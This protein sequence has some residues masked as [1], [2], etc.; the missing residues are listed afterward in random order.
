MK[1]CRTSWGQKAF[2]M[3]NNE[4]KFDR[5]M[6]FCPHKGMDLAKICISNMVYCNSLIASVNCCN[7][8]VKEKRDR[9]EYR[10][11]KELR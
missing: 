11:T 7:R 10:E 5:V 8:V 1:S 6:T 2:L 9:K 3:L 4:P